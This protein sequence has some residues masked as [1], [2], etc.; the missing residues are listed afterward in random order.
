VDRRSASAQLKVIVVDD[1][2]DTVDTLALLLGDAGHQVHKCYSGKDVLP[3][4]RVFRP[5]VIIL[6]IQVPGISGY[7]VAQEIRHSFMEARRPLMVAITGKWGETPDRLI[8]GQVGFDHHLLKP[9]DP[10][11]LFELLKPLTPV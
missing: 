9:C 4:A 7:A 11:K 8:A 3:A 10:A 6:D 5:D 2:R 1:D